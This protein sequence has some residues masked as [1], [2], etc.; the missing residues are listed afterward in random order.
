MLFVYFVFLI[1]WGSFLIILDLPKMFYMFLS[2]IYFNTSITLIRYLFYTLCGCKDTENFPYT[3]AR[4][5]PLAIFTHKTL[6]FTQKR[7]PYE[8]L[9]ASIVLFIDTRL[10]HSIPT[11]ARRNSI[12]VCRLRCT[13]VLPLNYPLPSPF[14]S[15]PVYVR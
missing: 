10:T 4:T 12:S 11:I 14:W 8:A 6:I 9:F 1:F 15:L 3:Q 13:A 5:R 2:Y 7:T